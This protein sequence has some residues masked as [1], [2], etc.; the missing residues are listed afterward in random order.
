MD[1]LFDS[2]TQQLTEDRRA[3]LA[4]G[5]LS[6]AALTEDFDRK[7]DEAKRVQEYV[8]ALAKLD[9]VLSNSQ[10]FMAGLRGET[11]ALGNAFERFGA[12]VGNAFGDVR[13]LFDGLKNAVL[14]F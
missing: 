11:D 9:P 5:R 7:Q 4:Q 1:T 12:G 2:A 13:N 3:Q 6:R 8:D 14:G 10:R